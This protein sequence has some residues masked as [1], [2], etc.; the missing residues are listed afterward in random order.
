MGKSFYEIEKFEIIN[1][2]PHYNDKILVISKNSQGYSRV[3]INKKA[4]RL[5]RIIAEKYIPNPENHPIV[6][7]KDDNKENNKINNLQWISYSENSKKAYSSNDKMKT[8]HNSECRRIIIS[9]KDGVI[10]EHT[11]LRKCG[12]YL[13]RDVAA[14]YRALNG[15]WK[16][17]AGHKLTY[18]LIKIVD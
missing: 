16:L 11:S 8:M 10:K 18:K 13:N 7:H 4:V 15:E 9:E 3:M 2:I 5:H 17:C 6:D 1:D 12:S 14:V